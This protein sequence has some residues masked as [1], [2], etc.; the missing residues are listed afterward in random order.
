MCSALAVWSAHGVQYVFVVK[1]GR[2]Q[3]PA[4]PLPNDRPSGGSLARS[5]LAGQQY[6]HD[7]GRL[8]LDPLGTCYLQS[9]AESVAGPRHCSGEAIGLRLEARKTKGD[10]EVLV[11]DHAAES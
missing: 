8:R 2:F 11:V 6:G 7:Y 10:V 4:F 5:N 3:Q 9:C 1:A